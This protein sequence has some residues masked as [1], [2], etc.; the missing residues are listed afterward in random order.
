MAYKREQKQ[1]AA[2]K[3]EPI[4]IDSLKVLRAHRWQGGNV[5]FDVEINGVRIYGCRIVDMEDATFVS[6]PSRKGKDGKYYAYASAVLDDAATESICKQL[7][8]LLDNPAEN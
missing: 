2:A 6:F 3:P 5:T 8:D 7:D 1:R 4:K